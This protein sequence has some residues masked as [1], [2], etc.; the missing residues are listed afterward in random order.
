[1]ARIRLAF[2]AALILDFP[3]Q[4][5]SS[6]FL[7]SWKMVLL[8]K[9][10]IRNC[11]NDSDRILGPGKRTQFAEKLLVMTY[12]YLFICNLCYDLSFTEGLRMYLC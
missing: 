8:R 4:K 5:L 1:M 9:F 10:V 11:F 6:T 7:K 2:Y 12:A 3:A